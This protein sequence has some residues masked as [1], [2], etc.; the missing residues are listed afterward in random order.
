MPIEYSSKLLKNRDNRFDY[1]KEDIH[2]KNSEYMRKSYETACELAQIYNWEEIKCIS[3]GK[4]RDINEI[5]KEIED[6]IKD[7]INL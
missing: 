3:D 6:K 7:I 5:S 4:I 2:E 1:K